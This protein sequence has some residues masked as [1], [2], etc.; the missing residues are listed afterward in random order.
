[1]TAERG[2]RDGSG[3][4]RWRHLAWAG[5]LCLLLVLA[6]ALAGLNGRQVSAPDWLRER[7]AERVAQ[8]VPGVAPR[9]GDISM[10]FA[11]GEPLRVRL[12]DVE[13]REPDGGI[14]AELAALEAGFSP[15]AALRGQPVLRNVRASGVILQMARQPDGTLMIAMSGSFGGGEMLGL[16]T[17][18]ARID[19]ALADPRLAELRGITVD[20]VTVRYEDARAGRGWTA[21]GGL[22]RLTREAGQLR[23]AG[24]ISVL[25]QS[26]Q[27]ARLEL[28][29]ASPIGSPEVR[30]GV[31]LHDLP[32]QDIATQ[33]PA[34][35]WLDALR[36]PISGA[37]RTRVR[38]D[39]TLGTLNATL[40]IGKGALQPTARTRA[41]PFD[42][43]RTYLTYDP[44]SAVLRF[45]E[46]AVSSPL[47]EVSASGR[48]LLAGAE[49]GWPDAIEAQMRVTRLALAEGAALERAVTLEGAD[50]AFKL[51][52]D[53]FRVT[54][55]RL[56]VTDETLPVRLSGR[57]AAE[58]MGWVLGVDARLEET[59]PEEILTWWPAEFRPQLRDWMR[60]NLLGGVLHDVVFALRSTAG[61][62]PEI[63]LDAGFEG[64]RL[65]YSPD[66][67]EVREG[68]GQVSI[69]DHRLGVWLASGVAE[70]GRGGALR[71]DGSR[72]SIADLREDPRIGQLELRAEG[73]AEA[74][75][76]Y[77][78]NP[79]WRV[80][81]RTGRDAGLATG[82]AELSGTLR[83]PLMRDIPRD[84]IA[85]DFEGVLRNVRSD[86]LVPGRSLAAEELRLRLDGDRV[87]IEGGVTLAGLAAEGRWTQPIRGGGPGTVRAE[88]ELSPEG[89]R[90]FGIALPDGMLSGRGTAELELD[91]RED[92]PPDFRLTSALAGIGMEIAPLGWRLARGSL[93]RFEIEGRLG[94]PAQVDRIAL[95]GAGL[96][97][98][99]SLTLRQDG[100]FDALRLDRLVLDD[101]LD[102]AGVLTARGAGQM[103]AIELTGG[104]VD[105]RGL[106]ADR[107]G[108]GGGG[109]ATPLRLA[110]DRLDVT[111]RIRVEDL[112]GS[113]S[114]GPALVGS[115]EG[116]LGGEE[117]IVGETSAAPGGTAL[118]VYAEDAGDAVDGA[119]LPFRLENGP[120]ELRLV[121]VPGVAGTYDGRLSISET[122]LRGMSAVAAL[123]DAISLVGI[124]DQLNGPGIFFSEVDARFRLGPELIVLQEGSAVG[125][126]MGI[127]LD[128]YIDLASQQVDL[129][130]VLSPIYIL[131]GIG[132]LVSRRGEGL[133]GFNFNLRGPFSGPR[134]TVNPLSA[135]TPG[136][137]RD[138]FRRPRPEVS[139]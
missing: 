68:R 81:S 85:M 56:R 30:L 11:W 73:S 88:V 133:I 106:P 91:F 134:V 35:A 8:V 25:G 121:P 57:F 129:Q 80:L 26:A 119:G 131:N 14:A 33:S 47:G 31:T 125:P 3:R 6:G 71:L 94:E 37:L 17:V 1:M 90:D 107:G 23:L 41:L 12:S 46:I 115:F 102:V 32:A 79:A 130:G 43:A 109:G 116:V 5:P 67:A 76:A 55:G 104:R 2:R 7:V 110:L 66:L 123:L 84:E 99:G 83:L 44:D 103:P 138:I 113:F 4:R 9:F 112:R 52:L 101:W 69:H 21:D 74:A 40:Q 137:F 132:Q 114:L 77:I 13:L 34:L 38:A 24:N 15:W 92:G 98:E 100:G 86:A 72:F 82:R 65:R 42:E 59:T 62:P 53:P 139:Q 60:D 95:S 78:D 54:L 135:L 111:D 70:P 93:G 89:L 48:A 87:E 124:L 120:L 49:D 118:L 126:S 105:I 96:D 27:A 128:G 75:L 39:G 122:R 18:L 16:D 136:I 58:S 51:S 50:A 64:M 22:V 10:R 108:S 45:D 97:A 36:A 20:G 29:A 61:E 28:N 19:A 127:S 117:E 63:H